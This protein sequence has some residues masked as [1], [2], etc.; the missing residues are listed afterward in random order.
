MLTVWKFGLP[1]P[2]VHLLQ[3]PKDANIL[4]FVKS[5]ENN[6]CFWAEVDSEAP[7]EGRVFEVIK[8]GAPVA[9]GPVTVAGVTYKRRYI[10]SDSFLETSFKH[11][12][13]HLYER[14]PV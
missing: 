13:W 6:L 2:G 7:T 5:Q 9:Q 12:V 3:M 8:T 14:I 10:G 11:V 4:S 1:G